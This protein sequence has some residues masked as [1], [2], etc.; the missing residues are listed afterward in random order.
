MFLFPLAVT[1]YLDDFFTRFFTARPRGFLLTTT[2]DSL[3]FL[4]FERM[5]TD[6]SKDTSC[7]DI[8]CLEHG[9][10]E[11]KITRLLPLRSLDIRNFPPREKTTPHPP[12]RASTEP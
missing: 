12:Q 5:G 4:P 2:C 10:L 9:H 3:Y 11:R 6:S 7:T 8:L 1:L